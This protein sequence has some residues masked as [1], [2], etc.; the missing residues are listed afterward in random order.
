MTSKRSKEYYEACLL[1]GAI[2]DALG[3]PIEFMGILQ[4]EE[5]FG[6]SGVMGYVEFDDGS[7]VFTDD[8][9]MTLFTVEG[10]LRARH[11]DLLKGVEGSA[12]TIVHQSYLRWLHTQGNNMDRGLTNK[13]IFEGENGWLIRQTRLFEHRAPSNTSI[14]TLRTGKAGTLEKPVNNGQ[15][16]GGLMRSAPIGLAYAGQNE[17]AFRTACELAVIT[18][19]HPTGYLSAGFFAALISDLSTGNGLEESIKNASKILEKWKGHSETSRAV[20]KALNL[21]LKTKSTLSQ[22]P[23][24]L[25]HLIKELGNGWVGEQALAISLFC[26]LLF[27]DNYK[28]GVLAAV[29]HSGNSD[30]TGSITGNILGICNG[31]KSIPEHWISNLHYNEVVSQLSQDLYTG[32]QVDNFIPDKDWIDKYPAF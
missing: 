10:L 1:G 8:T 4:I 19:G 13:G 2:G 27:Q 20:V 21:Y 9:Q 22:E 3:A 7:G 26:S 32:F 12:H 18:H 29:N 16:A 11:R 28:N 15:G 6:V 5:R 31:L 25:P 30:S 24:K 14:E 23:E 17:L